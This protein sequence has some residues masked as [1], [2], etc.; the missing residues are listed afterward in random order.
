M[1]GPNPLRPYY[2]PPSIGAPS[3][4][5]QNK[6]AVNSTSSFGSSAR[7]ILA[8]LDY[9]DYLSESSSTSG[10]SLKDL[11]EHAI[12]KYTSIFLAQPFEV[13][14]TILQVQLPSSEQRNAAPKSHASNIRRTMSN[15]RAEFDEV[16]P[17]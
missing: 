16:N 15:H 2:V 13:A 9:S 12:W 4:V 14:K 10:S 5:L 17:S 3:E 7:N 11:L 1:E 6:S 8:D